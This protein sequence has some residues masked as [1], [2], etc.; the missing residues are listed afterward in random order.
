MYEDINE[1]IDVVAIFG[2]GFHDVVPYKIKWRGQ[3]YLIK[4]VGY[5]HKVRDGRKIYFVFSMTDGATFFEA[6]CDAQDVSW[7]LGRVADGEVT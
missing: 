5:R 6:K 1:K 2:K 3:D 4:K 7:M